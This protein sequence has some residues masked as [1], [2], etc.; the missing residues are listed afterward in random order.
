MSEIMTYTAAF[1]ELQEIVNEIEQGEISVDELSAKVKRA[2]VLIKI[3]KTKLTTTE[4]DVQKILT[5]LED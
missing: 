1:E 3:C 4:E 5:E 2:S